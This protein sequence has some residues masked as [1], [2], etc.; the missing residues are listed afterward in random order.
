MKK[1]SGDL[2][3]LCELCEEFGIRAGKLTRIDCI[4]RLKSAVQSVAEIDKL[5]YKVCQASGGT[6]T[7]AWPHGIIYAVKK[8]LR[9]GSPRDIGDILLSMKYAPNI[10][11]NDIP[12][13]V[14]AHLNKWS[15]NLFNP[16]A[17]RAND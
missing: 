1:D 5:L 16:N 2:T 11:I 6:V 15:P 3:R 7:A 12:H 8:W 14:G 9:D 13:M 10:M 17:G 4:S